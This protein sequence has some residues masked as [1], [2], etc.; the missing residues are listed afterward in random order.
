M[1]A[2]LAFYI[3]QKLPNMDLTRVPFLKSE[4]AEQF[5]MAADEDREKAPARWVPRNMFYSR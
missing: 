5:Q 3:A 1:A 2:G 4:Y